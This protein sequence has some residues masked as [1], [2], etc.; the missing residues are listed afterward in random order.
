VARSCSLG[1]SSNSARYSLGG[2]LS[3]NGS[4][5]NIGGLLSWGSLF[6]GGT[7]MICGSLLSSGCMLVIGSLAYSGFLSSCGSL[8]VRGDLRMKG[9]LIDGWGS[10]ATG[11]APTSWV[12]GWERGSLTCRGVIKQCGLAT[13]TGFLVFMARS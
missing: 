1:D 2:S 11:L 13:S 6:R 10:A 3:F 9:S 12:S 4:L 7:L 5:P 8:K